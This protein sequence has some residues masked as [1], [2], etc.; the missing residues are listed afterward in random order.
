MFAIDKRILA[1]IEPVVKR[2]LIVDP[3][4]H[5]GRLLTDIMKGLGARDVAVEPTLAQAMAMAAAL[6]PGIVFTER[7]GPGLEGEEL[8]GPASFGTRN[9]GGSGDDGSCCWRWI[10]P[11]RRWRW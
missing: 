11:Q 8:I 2:V 5:A 3:N 10:G 4:P 9:G 6:E 7:T 1:R